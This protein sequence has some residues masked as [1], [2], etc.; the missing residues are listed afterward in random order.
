[1]AVGSL[2]QLGPLADVLIAAAEHT[3]Y[4]T[5]ARVLERR[6]KRAGEVLRPGAGTPLWSELAAAVQKSLRRRGEKAKL[7]RIIGVSR[8]RLHVLVVAKSACPDAERTL[9][10]LAWLH[11]RQ[12]GFDPG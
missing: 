5:R 11:A 4:A 1:M 3:A 6:R 7:A 2:K 10:L 9:L 12:Q 8:Q